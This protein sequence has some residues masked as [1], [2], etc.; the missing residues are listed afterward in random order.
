MARQPEGGE[1]PRV[2]GDEPL[3]VG[4]NEAMYHES[5]CPVCGADH[6]VLRTIRLDVPYFGEIFETIFLCSR[7]G[8]KHADTMMP[9]RGLPVE[10]SIR[11]ESE[12]DL[13]VRAVKSSSATVAVPELGLLWEP[14]P[15]SLA[16]VTNVEGLLRRFE[17]AVRRAMSLFESEETASRGQKLLDDL[18]AVIE[19]RAQASVVMKDPYG[20]S[21]LLD[22]SGRVTKRDLSPTEASDLVTGEYILDT[23]GEK[24]TGVRRVG[25]EA[26]E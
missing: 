25:P 18:D 22:P 16:E 26:P 5:R 2:S 24:P 12:A 6:A 13:F 23:D 21:A 15:A 8:F 11:V 10:Y 3:V 17:D 4:E 20:N 7:C 14:G 1:A 19:G 9:R